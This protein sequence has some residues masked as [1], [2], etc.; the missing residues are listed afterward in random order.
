MNLDKGLIIVIILLAVV[1]AFVA[2]PYAALAILLVG[3]VSGITSPLT[4][5]SDRTG[6]LL[7]AIG[8]P[9]VAES[10]QAIPT[11]GAPLE[12]IIVSVAI[13]AGGIWLASMTRAVINRVMP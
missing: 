10:L 1:G 9:T 2:I 6:Y 7:L 4:E 11:A 8:A 13:G 12:A 5:L 3:L